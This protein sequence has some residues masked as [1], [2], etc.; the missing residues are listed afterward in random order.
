MWDSE[1]E[2]Q[3]GQDV[4]HHIENF[5]ASVG[6]ICDLHKITKFWRI[7]FLLLAC[8]EQRSN[9]NELQ[10]C[11]WHL[12]DLQEAIDDVHAKKESLVGKL[13]LVVHLNQPIDEDGSHASIDISLV[14]HVL[15][16][17]KRSEEH[18]SELQS[19]MRISYAVFCLKKQQ[20]STLTRQRLIRI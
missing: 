11:A 5:L 2:V 20:N 16:H 17:R 8:N 7:Y 18:T 3:I 14:G 6:C 9:S 10:L 19:L 1:L 15:S 12:G 4:S 13:E